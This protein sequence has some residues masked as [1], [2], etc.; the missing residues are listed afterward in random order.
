MTPL[1]R[2]AYALTVTVGAAVASFGFLAVVVLGLIVGASA[3][4]PVGGFAVAAV[5]GFGWVYLA[6]RTWRRVQ[7]WSPS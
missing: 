3:A 2:P 4:G 5:A 6:R 7:R 1:S